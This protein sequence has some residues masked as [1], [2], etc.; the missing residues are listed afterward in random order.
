[1]VLILTRDNRCWVRLSSHRCARVAA[2][3]RA[4][5]HRFLAPRPGGMATVQVVPGAWFGMTS[6]VGGGFIAPAGDEGS[7]LGSWQLSGFCRARDS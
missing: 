5:M 1:V 3:H 4:E 7:A 6:L 2:S